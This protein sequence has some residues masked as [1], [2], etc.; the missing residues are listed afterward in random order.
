MVRVGSGYK[1]RLR[2]E[3]PNHLPRAFSPFESMTRDHALSRRR[4][5]AHGAAAGAAI[6]ASSVLGDMA[7]AVPV[8]AV[9]TYAATR[10][11]RTPTPWVDGLSFMP[12]DASKV[13]ESGLSAFICDVSAGEN[14]KG[15]DGTER[16]IR[17]FNACAKSI[18][19]MRRALASGR[20][21]GAFLATKGSEIGTAHR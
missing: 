19:S 20:Y 21:P 3:N 17:S 6:T 15:P 5:L 1:L 10:P 2:P 13:A 7:D 9:G 14:V 18:A 12:A 16:Y 4:F 11:P 8:A